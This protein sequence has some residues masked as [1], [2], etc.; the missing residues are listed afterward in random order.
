MKIVDT[1]GLPNR[2]I[3]RLR[4]NQDGE[5]HI[6]D[7][8]ITPDLITHVRKLAKSYNIEF[9]G[10]IPT[11]DSEEEIVAGSADLTPNPV[12]AESAD[13]DADEDEDNEDED[14]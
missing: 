5:C 11:V 10:E 2:K 12:G 13:T 14:A 3:G 6:P 4:F 8:Q 9:E 1:T 7:D